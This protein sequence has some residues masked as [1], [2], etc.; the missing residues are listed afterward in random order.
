MRTEKELWELVLSRQDLFRTGLCLWIRFLEIDD[1]ISAEEEDYLILKLKEKNPY[2][3]R[4]NAY[5]WEDGKIKP[6]IDW[7]NKRIKQIENESGN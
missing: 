7:I 4:V 5:L 6:R 3:K 2:L 1:L